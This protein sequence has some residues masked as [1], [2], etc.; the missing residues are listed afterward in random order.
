MTSGL[1]KGKLAGDKASANNLVA[2]ASFSFFP[3]SIS[4]E[5]RTVLSIQR[6]V[7]K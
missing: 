7:S 5:L 1:V 4:V 6:Q 3:L 2:K